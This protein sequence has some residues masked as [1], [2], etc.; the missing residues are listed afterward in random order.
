MFDDIE[1]VREYAIEK[2]IPKVVVI[3][4]ESKEVSI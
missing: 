2:K 4:G 1:S 3:D